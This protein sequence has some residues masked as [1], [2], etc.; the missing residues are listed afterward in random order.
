MGALT[1]AN[2]NIYNNPVRGDKMGDRQA[3]IDWMK[4]NTVHIGMRLQK[5]TDADILAA[6]EGAESKQGE[7]KRLM[8]IAIEI[9]KENKN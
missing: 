6:L 4:E 7:I 5:S 3:H 8:R 2:E 9:E 1:M